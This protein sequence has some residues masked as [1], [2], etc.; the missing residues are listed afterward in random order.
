MTLRNRWR[1]LAVW[2]ALGVVS[3]ARP[4]GFAP[5]SLAGK[6]YRNTTAIASIRQISEETILFRADGRFDFLKYAF[7]SL[8]S[9]RNGVLLRAPPGEGTY[10]YTRTGESTARIELTFDA[11]G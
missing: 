3:E 7:Q 6:V 2:A 9:D 5:A 4:A 10:V 11:A 1:L 8:I